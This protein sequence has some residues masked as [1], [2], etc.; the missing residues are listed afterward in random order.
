[1]FTK[2][3][4]LIQQLIFQ[5]SRVILT[6]SRC[7]WGC[8]AAENS[9]NHTFKHDSS[10][11]WGSME[12]PVFCGIAGKAAT[13]DTSIL[14]G[15]RCQSRCP[16]SDPLPGEAAGAGLR[17]ALHPPGGGTCTKLPPPGI[18]LARLR[19]LG[20]FQ[21]DLVNKKSSSLSCGSAFQKISTLIK[22]I[23]ISTK[24]YFAF[25]LEVH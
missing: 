17:S 3:D 18:N 12:E 7:G 21:S 16:T 5:V 13:C 22:G 20:R 25:H 1:M 23:K 2:S 10:Y 11:L 9:A 14:Y 6:G 4:P 8:W 15:H 24:N 19:L